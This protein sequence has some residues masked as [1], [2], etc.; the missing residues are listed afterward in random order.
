MATSHKLT[1]ELHTGADITAAWTS[2]S[3]T[4]RFNRLAKLDFRFKPAPPGS[5]VRRIGQVRRLG[6]NLSWD[7]LPFTYEAPRWFKTKRIFHGGPA[8]EFSATLQL[9]KAADGGTNVRY[10][11]ELIPRNA[12]T[13]PLLK[14]D[15][16]RSTLPQ[17]DRVW[18]LLIA[19]LDA[20]KAPR[21][22]APPELS[23]DKEKALGRLLTKLPQDEITEQLGRFIRS[24]A[25]R[26]QDHMAP[27][28]LAARWEMD[29]WLLTQRLIQATEQGLLRLNCEILCPSCRSPQAQAGLGPQELHCASCE[30]PFDDALPDSIVVSFRPSKTVREFE[31]PQDCVGSPALTRHILASRTLLPNEK[32]ELD[33]N[34]SPGFYRLRTWP[35]R[36]SA[37]LEVRPGPSSSLE[38]QVAQ[39][40]M[41]PPLLRAE[42]GE[43]SLMLQNTTDQPMRVVLESSWSATGE[44]TAGR[45]VE[46]LP[47][48]AS[49]LPIGLPV[50]NAQTSR[51]TVLS[52][53]RI[54][55]SDL[56]ALSH[57]LTAAGAEQVVLSRSGAALAVFEE[58]K[59]ALT[60]LQSLPSPQDL[61]AGLSQGIVIELG[62]GADRR[63]TGSTAQAALA[64][65]RA[66][67]AGHVAL[68]SQEQDLNK[69]V[70]EL[71]LV[72]VSPW[73]SERS[74]QPYSWFKLK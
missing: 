25:L 47:R 16:Q 57:F 23:P 2:L 51:R 4:D 46:H 61:R 31:V 55:K 33:M 15:M 30:I 62:Q 63:P 6:M 37:S 20:A 38:V 34:L 60:A 59:D 17:L 40:R 69:H 5:K 65:A 29:E 10:V 67:A 43:V 35:S 42:P 70:A 27:P 68:R 73:F 50:S 24:G 21:D 48:S 8:R 58:S 54:G 64:G 41:S 1:W 7:E 11:V 52:V 26:D 44:L 66:V 18:K 13:S 74:A 39:D 71:G 9:K 12:L 36:G 45:L 49:L 19:E 53:F 3:D 72:S 32:L 14:I 22:L 56:Q 28:T